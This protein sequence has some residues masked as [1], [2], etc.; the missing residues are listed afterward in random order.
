MRELKIKISDCKKLEKKLKELDATFAGEE[1]FTDTYFNQ[2]E[3][4]V[5][6]ISTN[7]KGSTLLN[8]KSIEGKFEIVSSEKLED[9][10][11][12][13]TELVAKYGIKTVLKGIRRYYT[14]EDLKLTI[15]LIDNIGDFLILTDENPDKEFITKKLDIKN[16]EYIKVS[17]DELARG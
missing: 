16:P 17:F 7:S 11:K 8:L 6:K 15:N 13:K 3:G 4:I 14:L 10:E 1:N 9:V 5:F 12:A 2:P